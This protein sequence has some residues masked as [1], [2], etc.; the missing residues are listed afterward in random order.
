MKEELQMARQG[1]NQQKIESKLID[2]MVEILNEGSLSSDS[3]VAIGN[4]VDML[5]R[6]VKGGS[7][8]NWDPADP[9]QVSNVISGII[10]EYIYSNLDAS[11]HRAFGSDLV[12]ALETETDVKKAS[13]SGDERKGGRV[14]SDLADYFS[15]LHKYIKSND[16]QI[17]PTYALFMKYVDK[18][19][20][21]KSVSEPE[22]E[23]KQAMYDAWERWVTKR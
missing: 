20:L 14:K 17:R 13:N 15:E 2:L 12:K 21:K 10:E 5:S 7:N 23:S 22:I 11:E 3:Q 6:L 18:F 4:R 16:Y 1:R 8:V 9:V 19:N